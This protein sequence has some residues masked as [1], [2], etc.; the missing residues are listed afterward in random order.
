MIIT[1]ICMIFILVIKEWIMSWALGYVNK[2]HLTSPDKTTCI[3]SY[4]KKKYET[5]PT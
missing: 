3:F 5:I 2:C 4:R 1:F